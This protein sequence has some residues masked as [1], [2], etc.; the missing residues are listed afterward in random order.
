MTPAIATPAAVSGRGGLSRR[1]TRAGTV[2]ETAA[3]PTK[4][5]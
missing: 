5:Q 3:Q 4:E 1:F 2:T